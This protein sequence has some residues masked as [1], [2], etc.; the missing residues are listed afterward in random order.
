MK[1]A[2]GKEAAV[3]VYSESGQNSTDNDYYIDL[4]VNICRS[5]QLHCNSRNQTT[6][7]T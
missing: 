6:S 7:E 2:L 4:I 3:M 1:E 5:I